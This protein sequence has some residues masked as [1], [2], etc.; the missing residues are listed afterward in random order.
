MLAKRW[1]PLSEVQRSL[2]GP[3]AF[4]LA[5]FA[6]ASLT[7][8][9]FGLDTPLW[10]AN[11]LAV[12]WLL[13]LE[14]NRWPFKLAVLY[15]A[16]VAAIHFFSTG[17]APLLAVAD[18]IEV[19]GVAALARRS[20]GAECALSNVTGLARFILICLAVPIL[21]SVWGAGLLWWSFDAPFAHGLVHWYSASTLGL[22][23]TGPSMLI[24]FTPSLRDRIDSVPT[25]PTLIL[26]GGVGL[27][28]FIVT[29][30]DHPAFLFATFPALLMLV[31]RSG[32]WGAS[33]G[34]TIIVAVTLWRALSSEYSMPF[35]AGPSSDLQEQIAALQIYLGALTLSALPLAVVLTDQR[36]MSRELERI[37][38]ARSEFLSAMSHE[39]RTP[40]TGVLGMVDLL[41]AEQPSERQRLYLKSIRSSGRHLLSV[42]NDVLD[43]SRIETGRI[44]LEQIDF[45]LPLLLEEVQG[46]LQPL[47]TERGIKL[48]VG[49]GERSPPVVRGDSTRLTQILINLAGNAVKFTPKGSVLV[50]AAH[51]PEAPGY[52]FRFE[53]RD[54][55]IGISEEAL[56]HI[57]TA[58][59]Q[60]DRS[61]SRHYGGSG[62][63]LAISKRLVD[64]MGGRIGVE[65]RIGEGSLFWF[66]IPFAPGD[67]INLPVAA[68]RH[69][70]PVVPRRILLAEDVELNRDLIRTV[71]ER[72][73]HDVV[74]TA[75]G[76][77]AVE[78][79]SRERFDLILMDVHMPLMD[80]LDATR[81]IR[82]SG[83]AMAGVRSSRL[84]PMSWPASRPNVTRP[85]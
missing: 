27:L 85:G 66:E 61:T 5:Y 79:A 4:G 71:L 13:Q 84:P 29:G 18:L 52:M 58:F 46:V 6:I 42:I 41:E 12:A 36:R 37:A 59:T 57:F 54:T 11:G 39:I 82:A 1:L 23:I 75:N 40:M 73:G 10:F 21:S 51:R 62:L 69:A 17:P 48:A 31:W 15:A 68:S 34:S 56:P 60:A 74:I 32:L 65:S 78:M 24:W 16:D 53:V 20:G 28:A 19:A 38:D 8:I 55:G 67:A 30:L 33:L 3:A 35:V 9:A 80:G 63:G 2:L 64:A 47:A 77:Q 70:V 44:E 25:V 22:L 76:R 26:A 43:F 81:A 72:D 50:L 14:P 45:S 7:M 49:L 83:G